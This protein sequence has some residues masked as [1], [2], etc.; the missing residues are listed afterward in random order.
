ME[1]VYE[2]EEGQYQL[3]SGLGIVT[4]LTSMCSK[5]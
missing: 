3:S 1:G 5:E 4:I 2:G